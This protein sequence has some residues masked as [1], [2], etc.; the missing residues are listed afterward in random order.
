MPR[1]CDRR[2][3]SYPESIPRTELPASSRNPIR[4]AGHHPRIGHSRLRFPQCASLRRWPLFQ[5]RPRCS[6]PAG[7]G[8]SEP[9]GQALRGIR[10]AHLAES[11]ASGS[12]GSRPLCSPHAPLHSGARCPPPVGNPDGTGLVRAMC[13]GRLMRSQRPVPPVKAGVR[14]PDACPSEWTG[15]VWPVPLPQDRRRVA[16]SRCAPPA[17]SERRVERG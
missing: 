3:R 10:P 1:T 7:A 14:V 9:S 4:N 2:P 8:G 17:L 6:R 16:R 13:L 5:T 12:Q 15:A 11:L